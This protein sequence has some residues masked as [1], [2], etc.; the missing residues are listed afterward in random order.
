MN[1][2]YN[3]RLTSLRSKRMRTDGRTSYVSKVEIDSEGKVQI[4]SLE[5]RQTEILNQNMVLEKEKAELEQDHA[6]ENQT[7]I[8]I[9]L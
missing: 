4:K 5:E 3:K 9:G 6:A 8:K 1:R 7:K 2:K